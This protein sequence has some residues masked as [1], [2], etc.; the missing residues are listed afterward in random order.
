MRDI[1][2]LATTF[3]ILPN[4]LLAATVAVGVTEPITTV[5]LSMTE[6]GRVET[7]TVTE[8]SRVIAGASLIILDRRIEELDRRSKKIALEDR[9]A[10]TE[11]EERINIL[12]DQL[13]KARTLL[14]DGG[15]S[16]KQVQDEQIALMTAQSQLLA[17]REKKRREAIDFDLAEENYE[18]RQLLAPTEGIVTQINVAIGET[19]TPQ[20]TI[21]ELVNV[22]EIKF[23][24]N[25]SVADEG[26][27][28]EGQDATLR[29]WQNGQELQ[30]HAVV[31]YVAPVADPSS[32]LIEV[33]AKIENQDLS[34]IPGTTAELIDTRQDVQ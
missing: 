18:R 21:I 12:S 20:E 19:V 15:V 17:L 4:L 31:V 32:G 29:V 26:R 23:R 16:H 7:I 34:V 6:T 25:F 24:G 11:L 14:A 13:E 30:R 8:G 1:F 10:I 9:S 3:L 2:C 28:E 27:F 33:I 22:S 5:S